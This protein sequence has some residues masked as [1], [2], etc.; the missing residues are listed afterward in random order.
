MTGASQS[1]A[2]GFKRTLWPK[3]IEFDRPVL[4]SRDLTRA[5]SPILAQHRVTVYPP[6]SPESEGF[7]EKV[8]AGLIGG[9]AKGIP[10]KRPPSSG[11]YLTNFSDNIGRTP[12]PSVGPSNAT[13]PFT[14]IS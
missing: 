9:Y 1:P 6:P 4:D 7:R 13:A 14:S 8:I 5:R 3:T 2:A 11:G 10:P 12:T